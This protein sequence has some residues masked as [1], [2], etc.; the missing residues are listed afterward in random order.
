MLRARV[1][2]TCTHAALFFMAVVM[3]VVVDVMVGSAIS[4]CATHPDTRPMPMASSRIS[5][6]HL[7]QYSDLAVE[8]LEEYFRVDTTNP[9]GNQLRAAK[10]FKKTLDDQEIENQVFE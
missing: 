7:S 2:Q 9:P 3:A 8:W 6:D 10:F 1:Q 4:V 5:A